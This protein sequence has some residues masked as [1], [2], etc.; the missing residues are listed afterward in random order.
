[1]G[2]V[3]KK[4]NPVAVW[5][6]AIITCG[7]YGLVWWY[8]VNE[9]LRKFDARIEV[10]PTMSLLALFPGGALCYIP[11]I[12]SIA[13]GTGRIRK[14]QIAAGLEGTATPIL[15]VVLMFVFGL[16]PLYIQGEL[17]KVWDRYGAPEGTQ[18]PLSV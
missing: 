18:V 14:A 8:K 15:S 10:N 6:L 7:I 13:K 11:P 2:L 17:N 16:Y 9:E 4:R 3:G 5:L 1:M 12:V